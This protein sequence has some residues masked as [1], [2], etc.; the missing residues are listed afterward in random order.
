MTDLH[1][2]ILTA[3]TMIICANVYAALWRR[4][5]LPTDPRRIW[6]YVVQSWEQLPE[7]DKGTAL[8]LFGSVVA[9]VWVVVR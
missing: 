3:C 6:R 8:V 5:H 1:A 2:A 4:L 7:E 9:L